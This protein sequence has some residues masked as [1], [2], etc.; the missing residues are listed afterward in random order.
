MTARSLSADRAG[1]GLHDDVQALYADVVPR[2]PRRLYLDDLA[3]RTG[4]TRKT[5]TSYRSKGGMLPD[6]DGQEIEA[7]HARPW[8]HESTIVAWEAQRPGRGWRL[9]QTAADAS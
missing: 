9:G 6:A 1:Y 2:E 4:L 3:E 7:G 5:L 8:W